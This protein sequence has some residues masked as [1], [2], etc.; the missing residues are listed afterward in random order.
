MT[1]ADR[2]RQKREELNLSQEDLAKKL[3]V[4]DKSTVCKIEKAGN[5]ITIKNIKRIADALGVS[6]Q[7]L[8]GW[9]ERSKEIRKEI[10]K[11]EFDYAHAQAA[12]DKE[13]MK[14][15]KEKGDYLAS[16]Y[17]KQ[18]DAFLSVKNGDKELDTA[19]EFYDLYKRADPSVKEVIARLLKDSQ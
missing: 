16:Q 5:D 18:Y 1:V 13:M 6:A 7:Y 12:G 14:E 17:N 3:G 2:I 19:I 11:N 4:K 15:C 10:I 8:L 9:E